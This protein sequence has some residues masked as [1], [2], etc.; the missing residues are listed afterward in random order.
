MSSS[1][2]WF[3][4]KCLPQ[5][6]CAMPKSVPRMQSESPTRGAGVEALQQ[7]PAA[8]M[9]IIKRLCQKSELEL[10]HSDN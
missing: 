5:L 8:F 2:L 4:P 7:L 1:T 10:R 6:G 9:Y 3:T